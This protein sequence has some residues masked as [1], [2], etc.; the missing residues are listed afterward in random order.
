LTLLRVFAD[1]RFYSDCEDTLRTSFAGQPVT[2]AAFSSLFA[3]C[4]ALPVEQ[5]LEAV[6]DAVCAD[7][8]STDPP[9]DGGFGAWLDAATL[10]CP[11]GLLEQ[12]AVRIDNACCDD[13]ACSGAVGPATC[14][15]SC[16]TPLLGGGA[17]CQAT[18]NTVLDGMDLTFDGT[19]DAITS[20]RASCGLISTTDVVTELKRM[21]ATGCVLALDGVGET[22][23]V[24]GDQNCVDTGSE[25][26][27]SLVNVGVLSCS[28]DFCADC[29][30]ASACDATCGLCTPGDAPPDGGGHRRAQINIVDTSCDAADFPTRTTQ[31]NTDCCDET[32][33]HCASGVPTTCDLQCAITYLTYY[34]ECQQQ[35]IASF[36]A[37]EQQ[38]FASLTTACRALPLVPL[39]QMIYS[40]IYEEQ[41]CPSSLPGG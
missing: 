21:Q 9:A 13:G 25:A 37:L 14:S 29:R 5:L 41:G 36:S 3:T 10:D 1:T 15:V 7:T 32:N 18:F 34:S 26:L 31:V 17:N 27:C 12:L 28:V 20:L 35:I 11:L 4:N 6:S 39:L 16:A 8:E 23:V 30:H 24:A 38:Q 2:L 19:A 22:S 33:N 40:S